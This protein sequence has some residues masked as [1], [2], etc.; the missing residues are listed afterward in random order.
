[1]IRR[2]KNM[3][4]TKLAA[5]LASLALTTGTAAVLAAG[6][7]IAQADTP[8]QV[9][10]TL[11]GTTSWTVLYG[12]EL[13]T[14]STQVTTDGVTGVPVGSAKLQRKLPGHDWR[15]VKTDDNVGDGVS[16]GNYGHRA[17]QNV[18][19]RVHYLGGTDD[20][21]ATTYAE[22]YSNT[23]IVLTAWDLHPHASCPSRCK[24]Y[25]KL[26]PKAKHHKIL[27]QVKH[28]GW[29]RYKVIHTNARSRW[30]VFVKPSRG[31]GTYY[32]AVVAR[33]KHLIGTYAT[34]HF[35]IIGRSAYSVSPR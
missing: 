24:F 16:F 5:A 4:M 32:R 14:F 21:T 18:K 35:T 22:S 26:S 10:L 23:V 19:Y 28:H 8:T 31:G 34:G 27:I 20:G 30:T 13:G 2:G 12:S 33:T 29:K 17:T 6:P 3:R 9:G 1:M 15:N 25:G 11:G 7:A